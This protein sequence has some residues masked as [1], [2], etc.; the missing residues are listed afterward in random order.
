MKW[1]QNKI[2]KI[3]GLTPESDITMIL[4]YANSYLH[5]S[6]EGEATITIGK[7]IEFIKENFSGVINVMPFTCM[8]GNIVT[9]IF[10]SLKEKYPDFPLFTLSL[11]GLDHA[12]DAV[13]LE[14]FVNQARQESDLR[15]KTE[16]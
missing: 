10:K 1:R 3:L 15:L 8:P 13:R 9:T 16:I 12:V 2:Y 5:D 4:H 7:T 6:F 11:D 14:T